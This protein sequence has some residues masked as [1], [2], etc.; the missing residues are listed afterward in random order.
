M[1]WEISL[2]II[3]IG[4]VIL[5]AFLVPT[6]VQ[7]RRTA[8]RV[9][10]I[11]DSLNHHLPA[12]LTN[13]DEITTNLTSILTSG[14]RQVLMLEEAA[15]DIKGM[16]EDIVHLEKDFKR[17]IE[18]PFVETLTTLAAIAR[19]VRAFLGAFKEKS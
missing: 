16:V 19:A 12:I 3:S 9:E 10:V 6:V 11:S 5:I 18:D 1:I 4:F 15:Q 14:R 2:L 8:K 13:I 17:R 7:L